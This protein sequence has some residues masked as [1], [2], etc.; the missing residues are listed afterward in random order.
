MFESHLHASHQLITNRI[1]IIIIVILGNRF[2]ER[3]QDLLPLSDRKKNDSL[4][5]ICLTWEKESFSFEE[6]KFKWTNLLKLDKNLGSYISEFRNI[7]DKIWCER[8]F[9]HISISGIFSFLRRKEMN[10]TKITWID[11]SSLMSLLIIMNLMPEEKCKNDP[12][13]FPIRF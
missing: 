1:L 8:K 9:P 7:R 12:P 2:D 10:Q 11:E 6:K 3:R 13:G 5:N 4:S